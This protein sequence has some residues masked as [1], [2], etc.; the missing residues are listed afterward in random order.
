LIIFEAASSHKIGIK[1]GILKEI[2]EFVGIFPGFP[3]FGPAGGDTTPGFGYNE[4]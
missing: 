1:T 3:G 4:P 2:S